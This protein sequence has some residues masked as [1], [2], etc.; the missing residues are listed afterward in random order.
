MIALFPG[1][2]RAKV[3]SAAGAFICA[4]A[5]TDW[6]AGNRASLG[7]FYVLPMMLAATVLSPAPI[8]FLAI[9]CSVLRSLFDLPSPALEAALRFV[10]AAVA[11]AGS[12]L[13]VAALIRNRELVVRHLER[14]DRERKLRTEVEEQLQLLVESSPAAI[15]TTDAAGAVLASN[16]AAR[17]L[18][19]TDRLVGKRIGAYVPLLADALQLRPAPGG[20]RAAAQ[21]QGRKE[22]GEVFLAQTWFSSYATPQG[23]RLAAI[24][25]DASEE[26]RD[27]EEEGLRQLARANR[28]AAAAV[29][30]EVR[31]L[32][33]AI[34]LLCSNLRDKHPIAEDI[35]F[36]GL[37]AM[38]AGLERIAAGALAGA[39]N[40]TLEQ[41]VLQ[42]VLDDLRIVIEPDWREISGAVSWSLPPEM[43]LVTA[44]RHGLLQAFLNL[45]KNSH[46]AVQTCA[47]RELRV[48]V[49]VED[50]LARV[51][52][53]DTGPGIADPDR[54]FQPFQT[55]ADGTGLGLYLSRAVVRG[56]GGDL[57]YEPQGTGA[58][59]RVDLPVV[60]G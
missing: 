60:R 35:D 58:C 43:P 54:L 16:N 12:G 23:T 56:Y 7:V 3:L 52:F 53:Q 48:S 40:D 51:R 6:Y 24:V 18:L 33:G 4:T 21:C 28:I 26:M 59:F 9:G 39:L 55:G 30:H 8:V 13:F 15:L 20:F 22:N 5:T 25:V 2:S 57:C 34:S 14:M 50:S 41:I 32:C 46:R 31:N 44:E 10:F 37:T 27:R 11:Y 42:Q 17:K 19:L 49:S 38:A 45:A 29:S 36:Q 47:R 1:A